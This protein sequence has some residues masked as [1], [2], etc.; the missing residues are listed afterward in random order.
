[1]AHR[2]QSSA[3]R[4]RS[5]SQSKEEVIESNEELPSSEHEEDH[6]VSFHTCHVLQM[7]PNPMGQ[8]PAVAGMYMPY[9]EGLHMDWMVNDNLY[10][11]F[12]MWHLKCKKYFR[13]CTCSTPRAPEMQ[14]GNSL[15]QRLQYGPICILE[16]TFN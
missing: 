5:P 12:L 14:E 6:E 9:I 2:P 13:M 15:E 1:M 7:P 10:H 16:L 4:S 3:Q 8:L 11:R